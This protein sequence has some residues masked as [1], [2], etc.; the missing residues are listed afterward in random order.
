MIGNINKNF[1]KLVITILV[2]FGFC[3]SK[4]Q[5][6]TEPVRL[7]GIVVDADSGEEIPYV[8]INISG[9][10]Y[11][12]SADNNGYFSLFMSLGD[13]LRFSSIGFQDAAFIM[14][15]NLESDTYSLVQLM[16]KET[17]MLQEVVVFP[18][19]TLESFKKAFME[20]EDESPDSMEELV[21]EV[22]IDYNQLSDEVTESEYYYEQK[23]YQ[24]LYELHN[25]VPPNNFLNPMRWSNFMRDLK[26]KDDEDDE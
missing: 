6:T 16:R 9:T 7:T 12:T 3:A 11:G 5:I 4:A 22:R 14:P 2:A 1:L 21:R 19:P 18:W 15:Y 13:T 25:R 10:Q 26:K 8:N 23:R 17:V 20:V 24:R